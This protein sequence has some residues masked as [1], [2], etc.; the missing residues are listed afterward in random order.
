MTSPGH[1]KL[2]SDLAELKLHRIAELYPR[3]AQRGG[4]QWQF[5]AGRAGHSDR[6]RSRRPPATGSG[7]PHQA[8]PPAPTQDTARIRLHVP[9]ADPQAGDRT[10]VR[11]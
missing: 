7:T 10:I 3:G 8:R 6:G 1:D 4:P 5:H 9:Q 2:L 11:L